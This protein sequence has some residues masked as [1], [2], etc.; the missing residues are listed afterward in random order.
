MR[1]TSILTALFFFVASSFS[2]VQQIAV[3]SAP[4]P[5]GYGI[6]LEV[7]NDN[8]GPVFGAAGLADLTGFSTYRVYV[9]TNNA[10]DFVSSI[11]GDIANPTYVNTTT[12]FWHDLATGAN[13]GGGIQAF[14][15]GSSR[16]SIT[17]VG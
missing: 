15:S 11:S 6:E 12:S 10:D 5:E 3:N 2:Q 4:A 7:V 16:P 17:T 8:I 14:C 9:V 1:L 13:T